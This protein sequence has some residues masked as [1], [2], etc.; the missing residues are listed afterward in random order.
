MGLRGFTDEPL[1]AE[2]ATANRTW[3]EQRIASELL[4]KLGIRVCLANRLISSAFLQFA[5]HRHRPHRALS[6][7]PP[8]PR[9]P[10]TTMSPSGDARVLR[11]DRL[12]GVVHEYELAA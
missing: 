3:G 11:R 12:G 2:M 7:A 6:L 1:I 10:A 8:E 9:R 5:I 4:V